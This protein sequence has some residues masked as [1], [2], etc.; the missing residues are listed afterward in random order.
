MDLLTFLFGRNSSFVLAYYQGYTVALF[1]FDFYVNLRQYRRLARNTS[2]P[3]ELR[4]AKLDKEDVRKAQAYRKDKMCCFL[5]VA[6]L[7]SRF[8]GLVVQVVDLFVELSFLKFRLFHKL[9]TIASTSNLEMINYISQDVSRLCCALTLTSWPPCSSSPYSTTS[10][11]S[12]SPLLL[13]STGLSSLS[14]AMG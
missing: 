8:L 10:P 9:W 11:R 6:T 13:T 14:S 7:S 5:V 4:Q 3:E 1:T 2:I 12:P